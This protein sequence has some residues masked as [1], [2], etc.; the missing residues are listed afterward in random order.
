VA[1]LQ[2]GFCL[3]PPDIVIILPWSENLDKALVRNVTNKDRHTTSWRI[4]WRRISPRGFMRNV[5]SPSSLE[6]A[7]E[8]MRSDLY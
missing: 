2:K 6:A 5:Q 8:Q 4:S 3:L 1:D 7:A